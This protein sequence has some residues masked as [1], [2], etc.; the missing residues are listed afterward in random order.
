MNWKRVKKYIKDIIRPIYYYYKYYEIRFVY[1]LKRNKILRAEDIPIIINNINR[2]S[3]LKKLIASLEKRNLRNIYILDNASTYIPLL[4]YYKTIP[5]EVIYLGRNVG[6]LALWHTKVYKR[7]YRDYYV[8]T[9]SD[10]EIIEECPT[11]FLQTFLDEMIKNVA[12]DKI[13]LGLKIDDLPDHFQNKQQVITWEKQFHTERL[14][15][16][17]YKANVDTTFSLY[18]PGR[19]HGANKYLLMYRSAFPYE[20]RHL[21]WYL[22]LKKLSEEELFYI[23]NAKTSTHWTVLSNI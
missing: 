5:Y 14:N 16:M 19:T 23:Q 1:Q 2:L 8:Y 11:N 15:D 22:D 20:L 7:F 12:V 9:D 18:R 17:Y 3:F 10:V 21:P 6:H 4:E 13:G